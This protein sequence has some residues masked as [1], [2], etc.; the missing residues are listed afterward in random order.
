MKKL[1]EEFETPSIPKWK[2]LLVKELKSLDGND[3]LSYT[4]EIEGINIHGNYDTL[5]SQIIKLQN[6]T[7]DWQIGVEINV[8]SCDL[9]NKKALQL[10]NTGAN[11]LN[12]DLRNTKDLN[13]S[14]LLESIGVEFIYLYFTTNNSIQEQQLTDWFSD[15]T[16][17]FSQINSNQNSV[18]TFEINAIG[19]NATQEL[20]YALA[21]GKEL[22]SKNSKGTL[23]FTFGIG[24]NF[25]IEIAKFRAF[26]LLWDKLTTVY[27][28]SI[29]TTI[30]AKT[31]FVNKSLKDPFTNI[32]RQ[33]TEGLSAVLAGIDQLI[34]QPYDAFSEQGSTDFTERIAI[35]ISLILKEESEI[36]KLIDPF[37]GSLSVE[38]YTEFLCDSSWKLFQEIE[39]IG[40]I[41]NELALEF[42]T[43]SVSRIR[44]KRMEEVKSNKKTL[45]GIN[46]FSNPDTSKLKWKQEMEGFFGMEKLILERILI[47]ESTENNE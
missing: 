7:N 6:Q 33:T 3:P 28:S 2:G 14:K 25:L 36:D 18:N 35:N 29:K 45:V 8:V 21:K 24:N 16:P 9:A 26:H 15:K 46:K 31:G 23:H 27:K 12:F 5:N 13:L 30:T 34:I 10:L 38:N 41:E 47:T 40:G 1:F 20:S 42:L 39:K 17:L 22:L 43:S 37:S 19:G 4:D 32:L 44:K 11:A